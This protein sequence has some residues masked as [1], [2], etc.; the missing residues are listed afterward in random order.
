MPGR[1]LICIPGK[2]ELRSAMAWLP[3]IMKTAW[4]GD[5]KKSYY[6]YKD[7]IETDGKNISQENNGECYMNIQSMSV[8]MEK[9]VMPLAQAGE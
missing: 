8:S 5:R 7:V 6:W 2:T 4:S 1:R 3:L 9:Y